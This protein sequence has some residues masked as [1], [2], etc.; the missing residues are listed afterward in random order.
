M[1]VLYFGGKIAAMILLD[2]CSVGIGKCVLL[3]NGG[4]THSKWLSGNGN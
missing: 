2:E 1:I 4:K 3:H